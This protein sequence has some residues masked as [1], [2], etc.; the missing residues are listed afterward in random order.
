MNNRINGHPRTIPQRSPVAELLPQF[1]QAYQRWQRIRTDERTYPGGDHGFG[2]TRESAR[3]RLEVERLARR[4]ESAERAPVPALA[5]NG[6]PD[7][8][9]QTFMFAAAGGEVCKRG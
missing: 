6:R 7:V 3:A 2:L 1:W 4:I 9:G 5:S 8:P